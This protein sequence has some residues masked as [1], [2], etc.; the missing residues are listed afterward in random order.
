MMKKAH[1]L[2]LWN[3]VYKSPLNLYHWN[4]GY[5]DCFKV[6]GF[7]IYSLGYLVIQADAV[8]YLCKISQETNRLSA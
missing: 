5:T 2:E 4:V 3:V 1:L 6:T 7:Y 8:T